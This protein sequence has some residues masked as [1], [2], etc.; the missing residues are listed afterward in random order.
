MGVQ[1]RPA[2]IRPR[3]AL[4]LPTHCLLPE[5]QLGM[6]FPAWQQGLHVQNFQG[7][8]LDF[9]RYRLFCFLL[10]FL[11]CSFSFRALAMVHVMH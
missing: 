7:G 11:F 3:G 4:V 8:G 9:T 2:G 6:G 10:S 1:L 5:H